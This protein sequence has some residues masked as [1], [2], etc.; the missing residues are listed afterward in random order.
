MIFL[1]LLVI[2]MLKVNRKKHLT[3]DQN[4]V[5]SLFFIYIIAV[6]DVTLL[7]LPMN[8]RLIADSL[9]FHNEELNNFIP[10]KSITAIINNP[11]GIDITLRQ[12]GGNILLAALFGFFIPRVLNR[13][14]NIWKTLLIGF[15]FGLSIECCQKILSFIIGLSYRPFDVDDIL[16]NLI[17]VVI[18]YVVLKLCLPIIKHLIDVKHLTNKKPN[19]DR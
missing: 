6:I 5:Y 9:K 12:L 10:F 17:G 15:L 16:L 11:I 1:F 13:L 7:P 19:Y 18:G 8:R 2:Y 3:W 4:L 14:N